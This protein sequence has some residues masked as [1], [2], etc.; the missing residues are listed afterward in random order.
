[1]STLKLEFTLPEEAQEADDAVKGSHWKG[2]AYD[3]DNALR[4]MIKYANDDITEEEMK[5]YLNIRDRLSEII[6]E[7]GVSLY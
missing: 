4:N 3:I 7:H 6:A 2:V 5:V 1:M